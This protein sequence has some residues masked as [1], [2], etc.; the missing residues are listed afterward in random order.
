MVELDCAVSR[1]P[2]QLSSSAHTGSSVGK[3][4]DMQTRQSSLAVPRKITARYIRSC[5]DAI[6]STTNGWLAVPAAY[7]VYDIADHWIR[8]LAVTAGVLAIGT[9]EL[10]G[11]NFLF[12][13][14]S[15]MLKICDVLML[16]SCSMLTQ[17]FNLSVECQTWLPASS[18]QFDDLWHR[19]LG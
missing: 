8:L 5:A 15:K 19:I 9:A 17:C 7:S 10:F 11:W 14:K 4:D 2:F 18:D 16:M 12:S 6:P 1:L 3:F 13:V